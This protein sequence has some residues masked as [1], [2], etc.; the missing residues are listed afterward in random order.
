VARA[1]T[2]S[3]SLHDAEALADE[4]R[5]VAAAVEAYEVF[6]QIRE[7]EGRGMMLG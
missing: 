2:A 7:E 5:E 4:L 1:R 6:L 3:A